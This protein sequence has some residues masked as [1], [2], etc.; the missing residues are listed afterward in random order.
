MS[1]IPT[2]D[3]NQH[4]SHTTI[5]L[6]SGTIAHKWTPN[7]PPTATIVLQHGYA[8]YA[9]RYLDSHHNLIHHFLH[10]H[11]TVYAM[12]IWGHG[13]SPGTRAVAHVGKA[14]TDHI[15]LRRLAASPGL[16]VIL[17]GHSL[18]GL[19]T[20]GSVAKDSTSRV[21]GVIL[22]GP[23]L[24]G[25]FPYVARLVFGAV[26]RCIPAVSVPGRRGDIAGLTRSQVEI[27]KY[28]SDPLFYK[29]GIC[30]L[31][32]ATALDE[33]DNV[34]ACVKAW[35]VPTL[36]L[37][38]DSDTYCE[39]EAS[40]KFVRGIASQDKEFGVYEDGRHEL[41]HDLEGDAVLER[42]MKW[43]EGRV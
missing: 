35:T 1:P 11:Y 18:G 16:R 17:F 39:W 9:C 26:A 43:I 42:V 4:L 8:E 19:I 12:D 37:H 29:K 30:F 21:D 40:E 34:R 15:E 27:D 38:G 22:T 10:A 28:F 36:V 25:P 33:A 24:P 6:S 3:P 23:A 14:V 20:A 5:T 7:H 32:A 41:L 13:S 31:L 2:P